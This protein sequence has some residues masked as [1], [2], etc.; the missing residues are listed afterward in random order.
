[1]SKGNHHRSAGNWVEIYQ[2]AI[3]N[4]L[5]DEFWPR[6]FRCLNEC[7]YDLLWVRPNPN[8]NSIANLLLHL[9]G[10]MR[11]W[12]IS[13]I[14]GEPDNRRRSEEFEQNQ[15]FSVEEFKGKFEILKQELLDVFNR[16]TEEDLL[17]MYRIQHFHLSGIGVVLQATEH[18]SYHLGQITF[19]V[20]SYK[21]IDTKYYDSPNLD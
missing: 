18:F 1:M 8:C 15:G 11:Q 6:I 19:L 20:K 7:N 3:I 2:T 5:F 4:K 10:N 16:L 12:I 17:K 13:G 14:G 9:E 21:D